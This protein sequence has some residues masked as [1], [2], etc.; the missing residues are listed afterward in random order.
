M[1][2]KSRVGLF[3]GSWLQN[4]KG[5]AFVP[6]GEGW[7]GASLYG[8][9]QYPSGGIDNEAKYFLEQATAAAKIVADKYKGSLTVNT[10][11]VQQSADDPANPYFDMFA[12]EDL[13]GVSEVLLWRQ[14]ARGLSTLLPDVV[15]TVSA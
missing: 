3:E 1:L 5:T 14:Y 6:G 7:P 9:Y 11:M 12:Q 10:G 4:F 2:L 15:I 13:S 8:N